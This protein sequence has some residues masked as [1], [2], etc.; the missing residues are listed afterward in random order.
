MS[1]S[2]TKTEAQ[3]SHAAVLYLV[4]SVSRIMLLLRKES[5]TADLFVVVVVVGAGGGSSTPRHK[6]YPLND[7]IP[8]FALLHEPKKRR[9]GSK[10]KDHSFNT[11]GRPS[12]SNP[13]E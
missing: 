2:T 4:S 10:R 1:Q 3:R 6:Q 12:I 11:V 8:G 9:N 5:T 7:L 13:S